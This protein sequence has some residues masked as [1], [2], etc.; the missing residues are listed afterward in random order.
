MGETDPDGQADADQHGR[1]RKGD[2]ICFVYLPSSTCRVLVI[3]HFTRRRGKYDIDAHE[4]PSGGLRHSL[5]LVNV[6]GR[7]SGFRSHRNDQTQESLS[8]QH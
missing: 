1:E 8:F 3:D 6:K 4:G 5:W 7:R 2:P